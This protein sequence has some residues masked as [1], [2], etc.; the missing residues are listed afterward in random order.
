MDHVECSIFKDAWGVHPTSNEHFLDIL[1][2]IQDDTYKEVIEAVRACKTKKERDELKKKL[3]AFSPCAT[4]TYRNLKSIKTYNSVMVM[5]IDGL[6]LSK[7][8]FLKVMLAKDNYVA[9]AF[10]SP[11]GNGIKVFIEIDNTDHTKH[12]ICFEWCK[13]YLEGHYSNIVKFVV[14][15]SGK[16]YT[17]LCFTSWDPDAH[18]NTSAT[19]MEIDLSYAPVQLEDFVSVS[20]SN[21]D[22]YGKKALDCKETFDVMVKFIKKSAVGHFSKGNRNSYIYALSRLCSEY[23]VPG[24][25]CF[26]YIGERYPSLGYEEI[27]TTVN[28]AYKG[29]Q[30]KFGT[31]SLNND[32]SSTQG[33]LI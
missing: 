6:D 2:D 22:K 19:V 13:D 18:Y 33:S 17:R 1:T 7:A 21:N 24:D 20:S 12:K 16:D 26:Q 15:A 23:G 9:A 3:K 29:G 5:D 31:K 28:S 32:N 10:I 25:L 14:D 8:K 11:S 27:K 4:F 30:H